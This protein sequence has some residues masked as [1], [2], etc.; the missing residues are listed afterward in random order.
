[1]ATTPNYASTPRSAVAQIS[2]ANTARD[3]TGTIVSVITGGT[4]GTRVEDITVQAT[5]TTTGGMVR[6]FLSLDGGTTNRLIREIPVTAI[7]PSATTAAFRADLTDLGIVL[8][9]NTAVLRA[10]TNNAEAF[11]VIVSRAGDF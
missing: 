7:T 2:A 10:A 3:G 1:M 6:L 5:A 11:N 8:P 9:N 4:N